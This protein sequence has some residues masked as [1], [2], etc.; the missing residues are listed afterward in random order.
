MMK[1]MVFNFGQQNMSNNT[2]ELDIT[3][4]HVQ[5]VNGQWCFR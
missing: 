5:K 3:F 1:M 4:T 2:K